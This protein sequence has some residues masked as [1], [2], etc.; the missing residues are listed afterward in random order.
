MEFQNVP[1]M[2]QSFLNDAHPPGPALLLVAAVAL[3]LLGELRPRRWRG[4]RR[5]WSGR[6]SGGR[7]PWSGWPRVADVSD[8]AQQMN[9]IAKVGFETVP[10]MNREEFGVFRVLEKVMAEQRGGL[11]LMAQTSLG[12]VIRP[13]HTQGS[14]EDRDLAFRSIER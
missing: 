4:G 1:E 2:I 14:R 13:Q 11:R 9:L 5:R 7:H 10:L 3:V 8:P 6:S 12:E